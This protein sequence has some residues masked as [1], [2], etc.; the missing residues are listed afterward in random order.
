M[1]VVYVGLVHHDSYGCKFNNFHAILQEES[2]KGAL[3]KVV[4]TT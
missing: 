2:S 1:C 3:A 4:T